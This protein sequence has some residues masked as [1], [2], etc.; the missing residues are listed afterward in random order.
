MRV[1]P[2][3][4]G[5]DNK[6]LV[7]DFQTTSAALWMFSPDL[8]SYQ[9]LLKGTNQTEGLMYQT[10]SDSMYGIALRGSLAQGNLSLWITESDW[11]I[12]GNLSEYGPNTGSGMYNTL[13]RFDIGSGPIPSDGWA[14]PPQYAY[15]VGLEGIANL[16]TEV[17]IGKDGKIIAGFG[18]GNGSNPNI[19]I[20]DPT[21]QTFLYLGGVTPPYYSQNTSGLTGIDPW[22]GRLGANA[23]VGTYAGVRVSPDGQYLA[24]ADFS[25]GVTIA[26]MVGGIPDESTIFNIPN[27][28]YGATCRGLDW[29]AAGNIYVCGGGTAPGFYARS[30]SLGGTTTCITSNDW[31]GTN[32][33][34]SVA[35]PPVVATLTATQP[36]ASQNYGTPIAG[37]ARISINTNFLSAPLTV[38]FTRGG[39]AVYSPVPTST[40]PCT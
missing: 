1:A 6:L 4:S 36:Y 24:S 29:D 14:G 7:N 17:D 5:L 21:G 15:T 22:N 2:A 32:G 19:Q 31:T 8:T 40:T 34:F 13:L 39:T 10:H 27:A 18:R 26:N 11:A 28:P 37:V 35:L 38:T 12:P 16:R 9:P 30:F 23:Q 25:C 20:L 3:G 33:T